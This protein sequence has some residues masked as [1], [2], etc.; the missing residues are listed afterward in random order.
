MMLFMTLNILSETKDLASLNSI[1]SNSHLLYW[2]TRSSKCACWSMHTHTISCRQVKWPSV[3]TS[4]TAYINWTNWPPPYIYFYCNYA[5]YLSG[6]L[7][8]IMKYVSALQGN[9]SKLTMFLDPMWVTLSPIR[10]HYTGQNHTVTNAPLGWYSEYVEPYIPTQTQE[11]DWSDH[12]Q[13]HQADS[14]LVWPDVWSVD[15]QV[16][17]KVWLYMTPNVLTETRCH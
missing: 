4:L 10:A 3:I 6:P 15:L 2:T 17:K 1:S 14:Q 11:E 9:R 13:N 16:Y 12:M 8:T 5:N 7:C